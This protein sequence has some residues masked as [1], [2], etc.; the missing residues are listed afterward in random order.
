[1]TRY[2]FYTNLERFKNND[3][4]DSLK[5]YGIKNQKWGIRRWQNADG[6]FNEEG[7][8]RYFGKIGS[9]A[10]STTNNSKGTYKQNKK[11]FDWDMQNH[12]DKYTVEELHSKVEELE[13]KRDEIEKENE[14]LESDLYSK[15]YNTNTSNDEGYEN[16]HAKKDEVWNDYLYVKTKNAEEF[17]KK[18]GKDWNTNIFIDNYLSQEG[19]AFEYSDKDEW[20]KW[21]KLSD[22]SW[23]EEDKEK[24]AKLR[25]IREIQFW[26]DKLNQQYAE[27]EILENTAKE[28]K[29]RNYKVDDKEKM[30]WAKKDNPDWNLIKYTDKN[31]NEHIGLEK[32]YDT[33]YGK[34]KVSIKNN[35]CLDAKSQTKDTDDLVN[36]RLQ[37]IEESAKKQLLGNLWVNKYQYFKQDYDRNY[38]P[39]A[40]RNQIKYIHEMDRDQFIKEME[41]KVLPKVKMEIK[42]FDYDGNNYKFKFDLDVNGTK[43]DSSAYP[44]GGVSVSYPD[45]TFKLDDLLD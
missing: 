43:I 24:K 30:E 38:R 16:H 39:V 34:F 18:D 8:I 44:S 28:L 40:T 15:I 13:N 26:N 29:E 20:N 32:E 22:R 45:W 6:T 14:N 2:D 36:N 1:M 41:N 3:S 21:Q 31:G 33:D 17:A 19:E 35:K 4:S 42:D 11:D 7:K 10:G 23:N 37:E 9:K 25:E 5:H 27:K 12:L